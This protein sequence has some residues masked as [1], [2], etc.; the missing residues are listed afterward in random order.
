MDEAAQKADAEKNV[1]DYEFVADQLNKEGAEG[2]QTLQ[3]SL[4]AYLLKRPKTEERPKCEFSAKTLTEFEEGREKMM[5]GDKDAITNSLLAGDKR[6]EAE[7]WIFGSA[8]RP[9]TFLCI[10]FKK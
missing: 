4:E 8:W 7:G 6:L 1:S 3:S 2:W 10:R 9:P 5:K